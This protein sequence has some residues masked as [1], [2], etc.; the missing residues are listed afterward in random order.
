MYLPSQE[1]GTWPLG[2]TEIDAQTICR[3]KIEQSTVSKTC[4]FV[5]INREQAIKDCMADI[6]VCLVSHILVEAV[7]FSQVY[8]DASKYR[9]IM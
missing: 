6:K 7:C 1:P 2:W 8:S 5:N 4:E 9:V 3:D